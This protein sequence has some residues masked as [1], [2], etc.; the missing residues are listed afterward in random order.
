L[1]YKEIPGASEVSDIFREVDEELRRD[2]LTAVWRNY[3]PYLLAGAVLTV[4]IAAGMAGWRWWHDRQAQDGATAY[5]AALQLSDDAAVAK[6]AELGVQS[7]DGYE[8]LSIHRRAG[9]LANDGKVDEAVRL[10]DEFAR[11]S[12]DKLWADL[13][14][15]QAAR[16][17]LAS[18]PYEDLAARLEPLMAAGGPFRAGAGE[19]LAFAA[20]RV[21]QV[22]RARLLFEEILKETDATAGIRRRAQTALMALR[23]VTNSKAEPG[24]SPESAS[25]PQPSSQN[26]SDG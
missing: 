8:T 24:A 21:G 25:P 12:D 13:A 10:Y 19:L 17:L 2:Q 3:G 23:P 20:L 4:L 11:D 16:L 7:G 15:F 6:L 18:A 9:I 14:R 22:D 5:V 1:F 26:G